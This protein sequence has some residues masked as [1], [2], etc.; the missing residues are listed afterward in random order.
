MDGTWRDFKA[1][2]RQRVSKS[3]L[4]IMLAA[5]ALPVA[6]CTLKFI[7]TLAADPQ[8]AAKLERFL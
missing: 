8:L 7:L 5:D 1:G 6:S 2:P 4:Q 3:T